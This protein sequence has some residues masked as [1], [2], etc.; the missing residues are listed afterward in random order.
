MEPSL[1]F[2]PGASSGPGVVSVMPQGPDRWAAA[3]LSTSGTCFYGVIDGGGATLTGSA[4]A[5]CDAGVAAS[6]VTQR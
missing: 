3:V 2:V 1:Q 4:K 6:H 5:P